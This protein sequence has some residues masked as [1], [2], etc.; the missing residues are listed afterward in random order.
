VASTVVRRP[1]PALISLLALLLLTAIVWWRVLHRDD[2]SAKQTAAK[3]CPSA[4]ASAPA[5]TVL[6]APRTIDVEVLN[7]T[8]RRGIATAAR[9]AF[10]AGG[11]RSPRMAGNLKL[12]RPITTT[13]QIRYSPA[14]KSAATLV[15]YYLPGSKLVA[16]RTTQKR[17]VVVL[18]AKYQKLAT[19]P[20]LKRELLA[21]NSRVQGTPLPKT[22][23]C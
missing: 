19:P 2:S 16:T 10:I 5:P 18:G 22:T 4:T 8:N 21:A 14:E 6:P 20:V 9:T 17:V 3:P 23:A 13:G 15:S 12:K 11:F 7:S 1:L